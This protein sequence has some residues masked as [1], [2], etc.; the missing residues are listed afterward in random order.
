LKTLEKRQG[1]LLTCTADLQSD[2][3]TFTAGEA[4]PQSSPLS[5][6]V[7]IPRLRECFVYAA[8]GTGGHI[9]LIPADEL[10]AAGRL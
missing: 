5:L 10:A 1:L 8:T 6:S 7:T 3:L 9:T 4:S 2:Q